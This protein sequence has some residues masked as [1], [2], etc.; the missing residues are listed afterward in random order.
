M[1]VRM[2]LP[3]A[4]QVALVV[5][6]PPARAGDAGGTGSVPGL[7]GCPGEG[8]GDSLHWRLPHAAVLLPEKF[9]GKR[10]LAS[11]MGPQSPI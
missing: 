4:P 6:N 2:T 3:R 7:G 11:S 8:N 5:Q 9:H 10:C 1:K